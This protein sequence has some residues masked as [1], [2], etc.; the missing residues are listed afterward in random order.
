M[1]FALAVGRAGAVLSSFAGAFVATGAAGASDLFLLVAG[2]LTVSALAILAI[3]R[4]IPAY[5]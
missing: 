2:S 3:R 4:H 5:R 1:G